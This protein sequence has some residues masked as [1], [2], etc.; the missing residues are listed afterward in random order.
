MHPKLLP[1]YTG[2]PSNGATH[3]P[4]LH[5]L[6]RDGFHDAADSAAMLLRIRGYERAAAYSGQQALESERTFR[7]DAAVLAFDL[8]GGALEVLK[9]TAVRGAWDS[10]NSP[11]RL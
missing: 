1:R 10:A 4:V 11:D 2:S 3:V 5:V 7:P 8:K 6:I 9:S